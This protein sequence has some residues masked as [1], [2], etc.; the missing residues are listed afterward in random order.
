MMKNFLEKLNILFPEQN[1]YTD[2]WSIRAQIVLFMVLLAGFYYV[3][4]LIPPNGFTGFD[5]VNFFS[6]GNIPPFYPPWT[7][8]ISL[9]SWPMMFGLSMAGIGVSIVKRARHPLSAIFALLSL[10]VFWTMFLGQI[11]GLVILGLLGLP[12]LTPLVLAK[13]Q[14]AFGAFGA[15]KSYILSGL[16]WIIISFIIWGFW[17]STMVAGVER[18][19]SEGRF[20]QDIGIGWLGVLISLP[21]AWFSR[22]DIDMLM[23]AGTFM[24][25]RLIPYNML[26]FIPAIARVKP[27]FAI[28]ACLLSWLPFS[29][30]WLG[31]LG[32]WLGWAFVVWLWGGLAYSRYRHQI[33]SVSP[34]SRNV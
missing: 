17:P 13:P 14:V 7:K 24:T 29:A 2:Q 16:I 6:N 11:D 5:W 8:Y 27:R 23:I 3:G 4:L 21:L 33:T 15:R 20:A 31:P 10:P 19:F 25:P 12:W 28:I 9:L 1:I 18:Y 32:W 22:G 26:P 34:K 30:N